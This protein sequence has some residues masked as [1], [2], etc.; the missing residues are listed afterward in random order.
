MY[1]GYS[2][3]YRV[4]I[5]T[6]LVFAWGF[7]AVWGFASI[8]LTPV[9]VQ[10]ELG[11]HLPLIAGWLGLFA[12]V[13][14]IY[15]VITGKYYI[16]LVSAWFVSASTFVYVATIW[17]FV[18]TITPTRL[19]QAAALTSLLFFYLYRVV[20]NSAQVSKNRSIHR[21]VMTGPQEIPPHAE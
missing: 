19:Q 21:Q 17:G 7:T 10:D 11:E 20:E 15:A 12:A 14:S 4:R 16:E 6:M 18:F 3:K 13:V 8:F 9:T 5:K 2:R 1:S